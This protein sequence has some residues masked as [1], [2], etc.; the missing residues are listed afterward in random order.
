MQTLAVAVDFVA[1]E[2][3]WL[4][5]RDS[6]ALKIGEGYGVGSLLESSYGLN[7]AL[8]NARISLVGRLE[9]PE[10]MIVPIDLPFAS[11]AALT[12]VTE[13]AGEVVIAPDKGLSGTNVLLLRPAA[14]RLFH[15]LYGRGSYEAHVGVAQRLGLSVTTVMDDRLSFDIDDPEDFLTWRAQCFPCLG[16]QGIEQKSLQH[17][18]FLVRNEPS[19]P[20]KHKISCKIP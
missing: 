12:E 16:R 10:L 14:L 9:N 19:E 3:V 11:K 15:F 4:V 17:R 18:R 8:E 6:E 2:R 7:A 5:S 1:P 20:E 13:Y